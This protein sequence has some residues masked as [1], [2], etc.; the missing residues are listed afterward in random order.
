MAMSENGLEV[1]QKVIDCHCAGEYWNADVEV[2]EKQILASGGGPPVSDAYTINGHPGP[3]YNCSTTDAFVL[4]LKPGETYLLRIINAGLNTENFFGIAD[5][6]LTVVAVDGSYTKPFKTRSLII[7]PGQTTDVL[8]V[9][10]RPV[11][12][13]YMSMAAYMPSNI[14]INNVAALATV[15]YEGSSN[16]LSM[17]LLPSLPGRND[18]NTILKFMGNLRGLSVKDNNLSV[19]QSIDRNLL[20]TISLNQEACLTGQTCG[21]PNNTRFSASVNNIT[22]QRPS[23]A[24]LQAYYF[25]INR[26]YTPDF[27]DNPPYSFDYTGTPILDVQSNFGTR[28]SVISFNSNVQLVLQDTSITSKENHPIHLHGFSF[29]VVGFGLGNYQA[30]SANL[31]LVDPPLR[32]TI[33]VPAGGWAAIRFTANNPGV[34]FMHC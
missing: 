33:G 18:S 4:N 1:Y 28:V 23:L 6:K 10:D 31:N 9:A 15:K 5:H 34:W 32:N 29:Y 13:Y 26:S 17:A 2:L 11:R 22:F 24:I 30:S 16:A 21:A 12:M 19:P 25:N 27:P 3:L 8:L 14:P 7:T 20:F